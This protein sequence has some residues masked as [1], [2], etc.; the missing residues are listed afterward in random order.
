VAR[1]LAP[2]PTSGMTLDDVA[3]LREQVRDVIAAEL[4]RLVARLPVMP[5]AAELGPLDALADELASPEPARS[6]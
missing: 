4:P 1:V 2:I 3:A 5:A 6:H